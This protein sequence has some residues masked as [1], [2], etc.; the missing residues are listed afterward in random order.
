MTLEECTWLSFG[1]D[2]CMCVSERRIK[3]TARKLQMQ[4]EQ[5]VEHGL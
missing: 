2:V 5:T 1:E 4:F 3:D